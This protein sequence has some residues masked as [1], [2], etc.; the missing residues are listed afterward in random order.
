[1]E[2]KKTPSKNLAA[3]VVVYRAF[4]INKELSIKC[5]E[6][7]LRREREKDEFDYESFINDELIKINSI[8]NTKSN[9]FLENIKNVI[10]GKYG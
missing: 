5:M 9:S 7:L 8:S 4:K 2:I 6:E 1:M 10:Q 3:V